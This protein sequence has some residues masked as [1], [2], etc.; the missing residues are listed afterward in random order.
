MSIQDEILARLA[1]SLFDVVR[2]NG[3]AA[4]PDEFLT[5]VNRYGEP[6]AS[7]PGSITLTDK[8]SLKFSIQFTKWLSSI[9]RGMR[10]GSLSTMAA[11]IAASPRFQGQYLLFMS[12]RDFADWYSRPENAMLDA[13]IPY[14]I[15]EGFPIFGMS[16]FIDQA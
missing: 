13:Y 12:L 11:A 15:D 8:E 6:M 10:G 14:Y 4:S 7:A 1:K 2:L 16:L 5:V 3:G 9:S